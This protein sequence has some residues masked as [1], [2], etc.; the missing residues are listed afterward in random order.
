MSELDLT[1]LKELRKPSNRHPKTLIGQD[2]GTLTPLGLLGTLGGDAVW[3]LQCSCCH[4]CVTAYAYE[5][6]RGSVTSCHRRS[7]HGQTDSPTWQRWRDM[8]TRGTNPN[9]KQAKD[10][11]ERGIT[12]CHGLRRFENFLKVLGQLPSGEH[13]VDR[14]ENDS[15]YWCGRCAECT[16]HSRTLN[17]RWATR[18]EQAQNKRNN[19][20]ITA[21]NETFVLA[22]WARRC[23]LNPQTIA[24][25]LDRGETPEEAVDLVF[26]ERK[27]QSRAFRAA[28]GVTS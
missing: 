24:N 7:K 20:V 6:K 22:E 4:Q 17:V 11:S 9:Y 23:N 21:G 16:S 3:L 8:I 14:I 26:K 13:Q 27:H 18:L 1:F 2:F 25:R 5:L 12:V 19:R 28:R 10:Y 15:G